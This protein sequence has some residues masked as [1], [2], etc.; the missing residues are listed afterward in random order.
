MLLN[1]CTNQAQDQSAA[2]MLDSNPIPK[3]LE[4]GAQQFDAYVPA[5]QDK[6]VALLVNQTS[7]IG[8]SHIVDILLEKKLNI[9]RVLAVEHGFRGNADAG[10]HVK[11][12]KDKTT[13]LPIVSIYGKNKKPS[14]EQLDGLDVVIFD[15]QDVGA[16]FYTYIS[17]LS[18]LMDACSEYGIQIIVLDRP[19]P[20]GH[21]VDGPVLED[22]FESFVGLHKMP[23]VH[24]LTVGEFA[25]MKNDIWSKKKCDLKVVP[26]KNYTHTMRYELPIKP[27][28][29]LP[30]L[31]S[32]LLYPSLCLIEGSTVSLGRGTQKQFQI[33]GHPDFKNMDFSFTPVSSPGAKYPKHENVQCNG[34]DL[35]TVSIDELNEQK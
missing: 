34:K 19:N 9:Q 27:S 31:K 5:L 12:L 14:K 23:I 24:G 6:K 25:I 22:G 16:R 11:D 33:Y 28:P 10:E 8:D 21:Y 15:I 7:T 17:S 35:S 29:N 2:P 3:T 18:Y 26:M 1:A 32:I 4:F 20:N 30:N 13:G